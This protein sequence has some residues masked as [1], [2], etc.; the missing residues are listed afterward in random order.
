LE[1][2]NILRVAAL[3]LLAP[4]AA[5][6]QP[7]GEGST[8]PTPESV[9]GPA[10]PSGEVVT[11]TLE[12]AIRIALAN[13]PNLQSVQAL[14]REAQ[15]RIH[16]A[17]AVYG[18]SIGASAGYTRIGPISEF[19]FSGQPGQPP[20]T[21][22]LGSPQS[23]TAGVSG[24]YRVSGQTGPA[25]G[26]A[27]AGAEAAEAGTAAGINDL[28][29]LV[30]GA[31]FTALRNQELLDVRVQSVAAAQ[32]QLRVAEAEFRAGTKPQ[33]DVL[34]ASVRV[35]NERQNQIQAD[36]NVRNA[37][38]ALID[39]L[40]IDPRTQLHLTPV[41][42]QTL[43]PPL[44]VGGAPGAAPPAPAPPAPG[45]PA[46]GGQATPGATTTRPAPRPYLIPGISP[47]T[48][49]ATDTEAFAEAMANRP[50]VQEA[51]QTV[52]QT[53]Q[54]MRFEQRA[55]W[56]ELALT[57]GYTLTPDTSGFAAQNHQW[58]VGA[59]LTLNLFD[60]GLIRSRVRAATAAQQSAEANLER[61][62]QQVA[63]E[64]RTA[65]LNARE[66]LR[67]RETTAANV[68]QAQE[69]LR[70]AQVRYR[71]GVSTNVEV[72][73]A[74]VALVDAQTNQVNAEYDLLN[75]QAAVARA[76]GR[77]APPSAGKATPPAPVVKRK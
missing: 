43:P 9:T 68:Q 42:V 55:R 52:E 4:T 69:A 72:T 64:V 33:Y 29:A 18:P 28:T 31:Y 10:V 58:T 14:Q 20:Q 2:G 76:L 7:A 6:A 21:V 16:E 49:P 34:R 57:G 32:E 38:T 47:T 15:A 35:E 23:R 77:Y 61:V 17:R 60:Y 1:R 73:D 67:R 66:A 75:A 11:L 51:Q 48:L 8:A 25:V 3:V 44:P 56:P 46:P 62:R 71:A 54:Q 27:R 26:A 41:P 12:D 5:A 40:G 37:L 53:R 70:I 39:I 22:R 63:H 13:N 36:N 59:G 45:A 65:F 50:E 19:T 30:Q 24:L 74:Q